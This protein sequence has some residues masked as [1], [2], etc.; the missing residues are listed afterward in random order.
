[1]FHPTHQKGVTMNFVGKAIPMTRDGLNTA[2]HALQMN[3]GEAVALWT[4]F[5]V[6]TAGLTQGF[7]FR[8]D[9]RPQILFER[10]KFRQFTGGRFD[11]SDPAISGPAGGYG[12]L[13]QQYEK[14]EHA[15]AL[16][17]SANLGEEPALKSASWGIGQVMGFNHEAAGFPS[18]A[19]MVL[20]MVGDED[21][22]LLAMVNF[23][24]SNGLDVA[25]RARNWEKFARG[26]NGPGYAVNRYD[27]KL[28][29][30]YARFSSGST[31]NIEVR[32]AQA[33]LLVLGHS[34]GKID[35]VIGRRTRDALRDFQIASGLPISTELTPEAYQALYRA[36]FL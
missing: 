35:G 17:R 22:Q 24:R 13:S 30:Q 27:I 28:E 1:M 4:V 20:A 8:V 32:T 19:A 29:V 26:Y 3:P 34:P 11:A 7:G 5:E 16:C 6:E 12:S 25:L 18:A 31:P 21:A 36:A 33:A 23:M 9:R 15:L 2:L 14:L 10:H